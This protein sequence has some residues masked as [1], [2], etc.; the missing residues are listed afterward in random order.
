VGV[1][2]DQLTAET[3]GVHSMDSMLRHL[4]LIG[5][6]ILAKKPDGI[7]MLFSPATKKVRDRVVSSSP[8]RSLTT[9]RNVSAD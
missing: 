8:S 7:S 9:R 3:G 1:V 5:L 6:D 2:R 4:V